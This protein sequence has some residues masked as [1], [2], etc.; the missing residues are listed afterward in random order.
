MRAAFGTEFVALPRFACAG[1][2]DL[3]ASLADKALL[4]S[5]TLAPYAWYQRMERVREP[6]TLLGLLHSEAEA[7][8]SLETLRLNVAQLPRRPGEQWVGLPIAPGKAMPDGSLSLVLQGAE[9]M[10][11]TKPLAGL[12]VDEWVE[13]VP[14]R[15]ETT[16]IAFQFDPPDTCAPQA[17]FLA[18]PPVPGKAWTVGTLNRVLIETFEL[19]RMRALDPASLGD[20]AH[21]LPALHFAF[22]VD[23]DAVATDFSGIAP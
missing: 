12:L 17:I 10:D 5:D 7:L 1:A 18:V 8:G 11:F 6:L 22:N 23:G 19:A 20:I 4:G 3:A 16:G 21:Y 13:V 2:T 15:S 9:K 14:S